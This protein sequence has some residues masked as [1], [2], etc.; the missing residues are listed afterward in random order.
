MTDA[1]STA[2]R[3]AVVDVATRM[4]WHA[5]MREWDRLTDVFA[6]QVILDYTALA[7]G[8][9]QVLAP[10]QIAAAW[11]Q[12]L[13]NLDSTQHVISNH[14]VRWEADGT[15]TVTAHFVATHSLANSD[16]ADLWLLGG[17]YLWR[18]RKLSRAWKIERVTMTPTWTSGNANI[19]ALAAQA[20]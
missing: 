15:A 19:M 8:E 2:E 16:G 13:G 4:A 1:D 6:E 9:P 10:E 18:L 7:G 20:S 5:D 14:L 17:H 12:T 3:L 11:R